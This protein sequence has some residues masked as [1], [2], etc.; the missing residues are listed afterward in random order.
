MKDVTPTIPQIEN[1]RKKYVYRAD[2]GYGW[3]PLRGFPRNAPCWCG[4]KSKAK[5]CCLPFI[6]DALDDGSVLYLKQNWEKIVSGELNLPKA[7]ATCG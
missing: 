2:K 7:V 4:S 6:K 1:P 5:K 3:N